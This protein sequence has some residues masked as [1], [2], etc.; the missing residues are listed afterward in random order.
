[1][2]VE[3]PPGGRSPLHPASNVHPVCQTLWINNSLIT[4]MLV[5]CLYHFSTGILQT[6]AHYYF[7]FAFCLFDETVGKLH[8]IHQN[9]A[10]SG[11]QEVA[12]RWSYPLA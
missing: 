2:E 9:S 5:G 11:S 10:Y 8:Q 1:M 7:R 6:G 3:T 12:S 4:G